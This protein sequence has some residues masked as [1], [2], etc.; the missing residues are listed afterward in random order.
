MYIVYDTIEE[1]NE[2]NNQIFENML[3]GNNSRAYN[4]KL[5]HVNDIE[6]ETDLTNFV[7]CGNNKK[8]GIL[9][10]ESGYT[11]AWDI[12]RKTIDNKLVIVKPE[13]KYLSKL[14]PIVEVESVT[15]IM[16]EE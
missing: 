9:N 6:L 14:M 11:T 2:A 10:T 5:R 3:R 13:Q 12:P 15:F 16:A 1:A 7:L 4:K 8:T